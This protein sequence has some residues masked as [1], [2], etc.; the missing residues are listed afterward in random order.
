MET[1]N[2][3]VV[4]VDL[5]LSAVY[6]TDVPCPYLD[7]DEVDARDIAEAN[8]EVVRK[9]IEND[10]GLELNF[11]NYT[12]LADDGDVDVFTGPDK[13]HQLTVW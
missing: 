2:Y 1:I 6:I 11:V 13:K 8:D 4:V 7:V 9:F 12:I 3:K 5:M 10:L